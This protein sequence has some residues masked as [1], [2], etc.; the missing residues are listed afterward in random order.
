MSNSSVAI[1]VDHVS[2]K[3]RIYHEKNQYLKSA[4]LSGK[5]AR[6]EDFWAVN[7][8]SFEVQTGSTFGIIGSNGSGKSTLLKCI[9]G[10]LQPEKGSIVA[11][12]RTAAL[13]ELGSG[14]HPD[15]SGRENVYLNGA[16]LGL[17]RRELE[18]KFD[19]IVDFA[20]LDEFID[21]PVK[22]YSSGMAVRLGFAIAINVDPDI[23]I[24]DEV[25]AVGD[26]SFQQKCYQKIESF[27]R[28]GKTILF[29][30]HGLG[31]VTTLCSE[32]L[33]ME[34]GQAKAIGRS[35]DLVSDYLGV[36][37][38]SFYKT[39]ETTGERWG[40]KEY[41]VEN[42]EVLNHEESL[43]DVVHT[44]R[45]MTVRIHY[46]KNADVTDVIA[47]LRI[48][49]L[50]GTQVFATNSRRRETPL[51]HF[52]ATGY[53][54]LQIPRIPMLA[55]TYQISVDL[56]DSSELYTYDHWGQCAT[57]DVLQDRNQDEGLVTIDAQWSQTPTA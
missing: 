30:S 29:V 39:N 8:V 17:T 32:V 2:K 46:K 34:R 44:G 43:T 25:L 54:D 5:R 28:D 12:G 57:F 52:G 56:S 23:L 33:W 1:S 21:T 27:R 6:Y 13:L 37:Q 24:I 9:A 19:D 31:D 42:V 15:L 40:N 7:D 16:L 38:N 45:S 35:V 48:S 3:F 53:V 22:N 10:I 49:H 41:S 18:R 26:A 14:F 51:G 50:H 11:H 36:S 4:L 55:G 20:G 47:G